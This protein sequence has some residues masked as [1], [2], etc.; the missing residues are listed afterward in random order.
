MMKKSRTILIFVAVYFLTFGIVGA[1]HKPD[2]IYFIHMIFNSFFAF[3][4]CKTHAIEN[5]K[6]VD[7]RYLLLAFLFPVIGLSIYLFKF[8]GLK[9]GAL[10]TLKVILYYLFCLLLYLFP[11]YYLR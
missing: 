5:N 6:K 9:V 7:F 1:L 4:W 2:Y 8:F 3:F 11:F 10:K